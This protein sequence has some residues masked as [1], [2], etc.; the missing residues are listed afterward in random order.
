MGACGSKRLEKVDLREHWLSRDDCLQSS[1]V[2][3]KTG[4]EI[5]AAGRDCFPDDVMTCTIEKDLFKLWPVLSFMQ[6]IGT[7]HQVDGRA[8]DLGRKIVH[9]LYELAKKP[10]AKNLVYHVDP[11]Q[12]AVISFKGFNLDGA[13]L[14]ITITSLPDNGELY[15][16]SQVF[17]QYGYEPKREPQPI[18]TVPTVITGSMN[19]AV[20]LRSIYGGPSLNSKYAEFRYTVSNANGETS[21]E[22]IVVITTND[23]LVTSTFDTGVENWSIV[24]N[25]VGQPVH[26]PISRGG[27]LSY[28]IYG[29]DK[30]IQRREDGDDGMRWYFLAPSKF[31]GNQWASYGGTLEFVLS[32][33]EGSFDASNLNLQGRGNFVVIEC[34]TCAQNAGVRLA[35]PLSKT[36]SYDGSTTQFRLPLNERAGWVKDPKNVLLTWQQPSQCEM[37]RVLSAIS[38]LQILGD[39]TRGHESVAL[40]TV[41]IK[42]G[43]GIPRACY[44]S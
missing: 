11:G 31:L 40:D 39:F 37:V 33:A 14:K 38:S 43:Q 22:A 29:L 1:G 23:A 30:V 25:G 35:M 7:L 3:W 15:Q 4:E 44:T 28:Y 32:S 20:F 2:V 13:K 34:N 18:T 5:E 17:S 24:S 27:L 26:Q 41:S 8:I 9:L 19:R 42:H 16:L 10:I 12:E 21:A 6:G 36:F